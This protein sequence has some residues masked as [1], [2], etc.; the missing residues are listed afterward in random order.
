MGSLG[1]P[2]TSRNAYVD[3]I[4]YALLLCTPPHSDY[5]CYSRYPKHKA[6]LYAFV[7]YYICSMQEAMCI[8]IAY[9]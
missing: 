1:G 4:I 8:A 2:R 9:T 3:C 7:Y 6:E 5:V